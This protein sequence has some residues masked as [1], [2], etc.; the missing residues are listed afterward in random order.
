MRAM[1]QREP[2][3]IGQ[4]AG[5][6]AITQPAAN[7]TVALMVKERLVVRLQVLFPH[8]YKAPERRTSEPFSCPRLGPTRMG[9]HLC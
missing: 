6:A 4:I 9:V 3:S 8:C 1:M 2:A 7:R 5:A